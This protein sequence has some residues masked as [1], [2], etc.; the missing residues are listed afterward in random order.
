MINFIKQSL[1]G[2]A[3]IIMLFFVDPILTLIVGLTFGSAYGLIYLIIKKFMSNIGQSRLDANKWMFTS[4]S[5]AFGAIKEIKVSGQEQTYINR[6]SQPAKTLAKVS[7]LAGVISNLPRFV[8]EA[9]TFGGMLLIVL[10]LMSQRGNF[11]TAL[12]IITLY[13]YAAYRLIPTIQQVYT[14]L[15]TLRFVG[16]AL[17]ALHKDLKSL[18]PSNT[19]Q[20]DNFLSL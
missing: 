5:D 3:I 11:I 10:Y 18:K 17:D 2:L 8:L 6:F 1:V 13:A 14:S 16:P 12:P 9:I 19:N 4:I 20:S 7:A 15:L